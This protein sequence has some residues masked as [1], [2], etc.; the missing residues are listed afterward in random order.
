LDRQLRPEPISAF[1][2]PATCHQRPEG[3]KLVGVPVKLEGS[4]GAVVPALAFPAVDF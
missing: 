4:A 1:D 2:I 3:D